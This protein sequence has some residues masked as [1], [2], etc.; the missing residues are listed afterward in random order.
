MKHPRRHLNLALA[1]IAF[2]A[3][4]APAAASA[5]MRVTGVDTSQYPTIR[6]TVLSSAGPRVRPSMT[7]DGIPVAE[8]HAT[9]LASVWQLDDHGRRDHHVA[10]LAALLQACR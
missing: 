2:A 6:A 7:E 8:L 1:L 9:N 3:L 10:C 5:S 4:L